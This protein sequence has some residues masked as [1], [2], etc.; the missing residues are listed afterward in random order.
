MV[1]RTIAEREIEAVLKRNKANI[2]KV[3]EACRAWDS[4]NERPCL[5]QMPVER[6]TLVVNCLS[7]ELSQLFGNGQLARDMGLSVACEEFAFGLTSD[8]G[9]CGEPKMRLVLA[10]VSTLRQVRRLQRALRRPL[11]EHPAHHQ[12][13]HHLLLLGDLFLDHN[14]NLNLWG[15]A[16]LQLGSIN[17]PCASLKEPASRMDGKGVRSHSSWRLCAWLRRPEEMNTGQVCN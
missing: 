15:G 1:I 17:R 8:S 9:P 4:T 3:S 6:A 2:Q 16:R 5:V 14:D 12:R 13:Y 7:N 10:S 11:F